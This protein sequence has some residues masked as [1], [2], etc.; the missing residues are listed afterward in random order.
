MLIGHSVAG[1]ELSDVVSV[2]PDRI[3]GL[4]YLDAGYAYAFDNGKGWTIEE[5][6]GAQK[7]PQPSATGPSAAD[8]AS[9][10]AY[11][12]WV[13]RV[14]GFDYPEAELR[15]LYNPT[16]NGG[17]GRARTPARIPQAI[18]DGHKK[19]TVIA[20]PTLA[21]FVTPKDHRPVLSRI[22]DSA[23]RAF[24]PNRF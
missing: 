19:F 21:I 1:E 2:R 5:M 9:F 3:A 20:C 17:V 7:T 4:I 12:V 23:A 11:Q 18:M 13:S 15:Q 16:A 10:S 24:R 22:D 6:Q 14:G 8:R